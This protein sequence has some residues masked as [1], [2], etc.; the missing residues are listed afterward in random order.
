MSI[1]ASLRILEVGN[2]FPYPECN[3]SLWRQRSRPNVSKRH[4]SER[5]QYKVALCPDLDLLCPVGPPGVHHI[6]KNQC[7]H[8]S[9][10]AVLCPPGWAG[11][12]LMPIVPGVLILCTNP[13]PHDPPRRRSAPI[14]D[15][16][17]LFVAERMRSYDAVH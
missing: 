15:C 16:T 4:R 14:V 8:T 1:F 11:T 9:G 6:H 5:A 12:I 2:L 7:V 3:T 13:A 17:N 10:R